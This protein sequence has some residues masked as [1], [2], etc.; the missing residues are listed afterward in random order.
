METVTDKTPLEAWQQKIARAQR[1]AAG[2]S[3][4][5]A[6][7]AKKLKEAEHEQST[8]AYAE[9]ILSG[10]LK[11]W[12]ENDPGKHG[13]AYRFVGA[14]GRPVVVEELLSPEERAEAR[15]KHLPVVPFGGVATKLCHRCS[16]GKLLPVIEEYCQT[17][18]GPDGDT[19]TKRRLIACPDCCAVFK[20]GETE[21]SDRR[22]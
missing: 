15:A 9:R 12:K 5:V 22:F 7:L 3:K 4:H 2:R 18:D 16:P 21:E 17:E 8:A 19:W 13:P 6:A 10:V 11:G 14:S 20:T 1:A